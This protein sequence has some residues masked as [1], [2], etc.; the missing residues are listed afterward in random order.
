MGIEPP[1]DTATNVAHIAD[2]HEP[3]RV[4]LISRGRSTT[5]GDLVDKAAR[6]RGGLAAKGVARGDRVALICANGTTFVVG[7]LA[8]TGLGA[9]AVP[10]NPFSAPA[11]LQA[12]LAAVGATTVIVDR[13]G[14]PTWRRIDRSSVPTVA[15]VVAVHAADV[16]GS[17]PMS[18]LLEAEPSPVVDVR[19]DDVA[20]LMFTSGT[21]GA[22]RAAK[23]THG[24]LLSNITQARSSRNHVGPDDTLFGVIPLCHI[25]GLNVVLGIGLSAGATILLVNR[26]DPATA[27]ESI[28]SRKITVVAGPPT[29]W[30][31][32]A[33]FDEAPADSLAS[34][35]IGLSGASRLPVA[36]AER[37]RDRFGVSIAEGYGLTE[38]SPIVTSSIGLAPRFGSI[39]RVLAGVEVRIVTPD[40]ADAV[41][42]D[43][44]ELWVRGPNVFAGYLDDPEATARVLTDDG[45]LRTGDVGMCDDEGWL[46][47]VDRAKDLVIV[48]GFN[49]YPAE[50]EDVL[51]EHPDVAEVGVTGVSN[52]HTGEAVR[53]YVVTRP[54]S[55]I[56]EE[57][58]I[59]HCRDHLARYK[60]P[61]KILFVDRLPHNASGKLLRRELD[62]LWV[63]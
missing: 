59:D 30:A 61:T 48:S 50:V 22:P 41:I 38:A 15:N 7:Y 19:P 2:G 43:A 42:G 55:D 36:V 1:H 6:A 24:N 51:A 17:T 58:L 56:D 52:P 18:D 21:A 34:V 39:G 12:E 54:G 26:F 31:A 14:G 28:R 4:A 45:W 33:H 25:F 62:D 16:E 5:Y 23:L 53:A 3:G 46:Y 60:C 32:F 57:A 9:V 8:I 63:G 40:G 20:V 10:L 47:L 35:R 44:G 49:V 13:T 27:I 37:I 11:E 29:L